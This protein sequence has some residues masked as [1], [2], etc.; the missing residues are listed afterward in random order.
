MKVLLASLLV[1]FFLPL[2]TPAAETSFD[3][4]ELAALCEKA[5]PQEAETRGECLRKAAGL[6]RPVSPPTPEELVAMYGE[7]D[8]PALVARAQRQWGKQ[9]F[10]HQASILDCKGQSDWQACSIAVFDKELAIHEQMFESLKPPA[11]PSTIGPRY[12]HIYAMRG[13]LQLSVECDRLASS[14]K[15]CADKDERMKQAERLY[16]DGWIA[17]IQKAKQH[18]D[19]HQA[20]RERRAQQMEQDYQNALRAQREHELELARIGAAGMILQGFALS[21]G[22]LQNTMRATQTPPVQLQPQTFFA[23]VPLMR[24][25]P[26]VNCMSNVVGGVTHTNCY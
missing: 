19:K 1:L 9:M 25:S 23:P 13:A 3:W 5:Y 21:G 2:P 7:P 12:A 22:P 14:K 20:L 17:H 6:D 15:A 8:D 24:P 18:M 16:L 26:P 11:W 4:Q 10:D